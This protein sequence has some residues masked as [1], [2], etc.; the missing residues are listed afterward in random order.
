MGS[1][2]VVS[3]GGRSNAVD[4]PACAAA[5]FTVRQERPGT[6]ALAAAQDP[7]TI[8]IVVDADGRGLVTGAA[9][10]FCRQLRTC[11]QRWLILLVPRLD[12][13]GEMMAWSIGVNDYVSRGA[14]PRALVARLAARLG[15]EESD[16]DPES[17]L[18]LGR[19]IPAQR[20]RKPQAPPFMAGD[21][22]SFLERAERLSF[23]SILLDG[24]SRMVYVNEEPVHL[25][26]TEFDLL[27]MLLAQ[28]QRVFTRAELIGAVWGE[29]W[30][31][32]DHFVETHASRLRRKISAAGGPRIAAAVRGV[33]YRLIDGAPRWA[34]IHD[35]TAGTLE[36]LPELQSLQGSRTA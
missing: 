34:D 30:F 24:P 4:I 13:A 29:T 9:L 17:R 10:A 8:A 28:P 25:T 18:Y 33:G 5:G 15:T 14:G 6:A 11:T 2:L 32:D 7:A 36:G 3:A 19:E 20:A 12:E 31:G 23:D 26:R 27:A 35:Q 1:V 21:R 22:S 16:A